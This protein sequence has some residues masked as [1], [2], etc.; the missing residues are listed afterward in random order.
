MGDM[1][2]L[3][4]ENKRESSDE[5]ITDL[6]TILDGLENSKKT[7]KW[8]FVLLN[9]FEDEIFWDDCRTSDNPRCKGNLSDKPE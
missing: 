5:Y 6:D 3:L 8:D 9:N 1:D 4:K 7:T 2:D